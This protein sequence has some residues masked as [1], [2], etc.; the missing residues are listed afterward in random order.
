[1]SFDRTGRPL[2]LLNIVRGVNRSLTRRISIFASLGIFVSTLAIMGVALTWEL[3]RSVKAERELLLAYSGV[4][5]AAVSPAMAENDR[6]A[7][8]AAMTG[9][10]KLPRV[11][12]ARL[13][14]PG[15]ERWVDILSLIHI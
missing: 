7:A 3:D 8:Q 5:A 11:K 10:S 2:D 4:F 14:L 15:G 13:D 1:M 12:N 9:I 6:A